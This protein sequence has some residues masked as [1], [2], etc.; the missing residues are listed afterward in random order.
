MQAEVQVKLLPESVPATYVAVFDD[1]HRVKSACKYDPRTKRVFDIQQADETGQ[2]IGGQ[3]DALTD[4]FVIVLVP[5]VVQLNKD[6]GV[7]FDY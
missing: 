1:T 3:A 6:D 4:E 2:E 7:T 5:C